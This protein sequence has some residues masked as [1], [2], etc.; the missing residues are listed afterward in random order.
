MGQNNPALLGLILL[1]HVHC[2]LS[3]LWA[4]NFIREILDV[5]QAEKEYMGPYLC[6]KDC[7]MITSVWFWYF[8]HLLGLTGIYRVG[9]P[10][11]H[12]KRFV[13]SFFLFLFFFLI[14]I[15]F[16]S[17]PLGPFSSGAPGHCPPMPPSRYATDAVGHSHSLLKGLSVIVYSKL[18][19][20]PNPQIF[21]P[22]QRELDCN[23]PEDSGS[24]VDKIPLSARCN[25]LYKCIISMMHYP[26]L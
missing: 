12:L 24:W 18:H 19:F 17:L 26:Q 1:H 11:G 8:C 10:S 15:F 22:I 20:F 21:L 13:L 14:L 7:V 16:L 9:P 23:L 6:F 5:M 4:P 25:V 2:T 3:N